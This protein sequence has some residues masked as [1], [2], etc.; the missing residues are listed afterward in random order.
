MKDYYFYILGT[1]SA[2]ISFIEDLI[3]IIQLILLI[4]SLTLTLIGIIKAIVQKV[5]NKENIEEELKE[6]KNTI[7]DISTN[8]EKVKEK[9]ED[10]KKEE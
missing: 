2:G 7:I 9:I 5:K 3:P 4:I 1:A 10:I 6:A 8:V